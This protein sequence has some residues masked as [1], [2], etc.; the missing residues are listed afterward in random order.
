MLIPKIVGK[1]KMKTSKA[2]NDYRNTLEQKNWQRGYHD[3]VIRT[4]QSYNNIQNYIQNN[5]ANWNQD[6]FY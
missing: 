5:V 1:F 4:I 2:I 6:T 3:H